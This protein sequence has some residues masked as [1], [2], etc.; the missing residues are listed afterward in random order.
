MLQRDLDRAYAGYFDC[1][2]KLFRAEGASRFY[3]GLVPNVVKAA[4]SAAIQFV[5][6]DYLMA[7]STG[8]AI[9]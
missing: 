5:T 2:S 3:R 6:F 1:A 7:L 9:R 4:P 8:R